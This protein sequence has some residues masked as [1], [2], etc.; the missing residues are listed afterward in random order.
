MTETGEN[1]A[2]WLRGR[3]SNPRSP[4]YET[5]EDD[6]A[7]LPRH[8][9]KAR[10]SMEVRRP[11]GS[12]HDATLGLDPWDKHRAGELSAGSVR[13]TEPAPAESL[14]AP[15]RRKSNWQGTAAREEVEQPMGMGKG[16]T[17]FGSLRYWAEN[18]GPEVMPRNAGDPLHLKNSLSGNLSPLKHGSRRHSQPAS[19]LARAADA[20]NGSSKCS[21]VRVHAYL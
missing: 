14:P 13:V 9:E 20:V 8:E 21:E 18:V 5:G 1:T 12:R 19:K 16:G 10:R 15:G 2:N 4:A 11:G 6:Q 7:P 17:S 3:D